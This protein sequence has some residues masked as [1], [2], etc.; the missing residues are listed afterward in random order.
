MKNA[1]SIAI[2]L[3]KS[4]LSLLMEHFNHGEEIK[5]YTDEVHILCLTLHQPEHSMILTATK[6]N[7][8]SIPIFKIQ[9]IIIVINIDPPSIT[10]P[11]IP[12]SDWG[13]GKQDNGKR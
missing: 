13:R 3:S 11:S 8:G 2:F 1:R 4:S 10:H 12:L 7:A 5:C 6:N 9:D